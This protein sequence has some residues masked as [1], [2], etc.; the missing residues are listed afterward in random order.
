MF[1][2]FLFLLVYY[3]F[4]RIFV[5]SLQHCVLSTFRKVLDLSPVLLEVFREEGLWDLI[6][7]ENFFYFG[8]ASEEFSGEFCAS[9]EGSSRK[10]EIYPMSNWANCQAKASGVEIIQMEVISFVEFAATFNGS[11][12][13]LVGSSFF[14]SDIFYPE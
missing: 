9:D 6:F 7:S 5:N 1:L 4:C 2:S 10:F 11:T 3:N 12:H 13:N 14:T 8:P